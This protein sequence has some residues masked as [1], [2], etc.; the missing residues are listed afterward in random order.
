MSLAI[1]VQG[2]RDKE[3]YKFKRSIVWDIFG[4][5]CSPPRLCGY[6]LTYGDWGGGF[7]YLDED[8]FVDGFGIQRASDNAI[9][10]LYAVAR[11]VPSAINLAAA[12]FVADAAFL[13]DIP[14][15]LSAA[16]P[17]PIRVAHSADE[18]LEFLSE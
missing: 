13:A 5:K 18:L 11:Q 7:L 4:S 3:I 14:D 8:E 15:W 1:N 6:N 12:F 10:D 2:F 9:R 17:K 16:L